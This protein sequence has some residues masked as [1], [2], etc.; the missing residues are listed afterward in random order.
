MSSVR[1]L[2]VGDL[3]VDKYIDCDPVGLSSEDPT[4][5][6]T[7][8]LSQSFVGGAGVVASHAA[9]LGAETYLLSV[10]G[11]DDYAEYA[12]DTLSKNNVQVIIVADGSR[13][14]TVK[15]RYR[16]K[17]KT[18]L[19][20]NEYRDH[21]VDVEIQ[22]NILA[23]A[24]DLFS[25][26]DLLI[27]SDFSYG[28]LSENL[29]SQMMTTARMHNIVIA[30]DSQSSSQIGDI[31]KFRGADI[32]TPTE[33]EARLAT[34]NKNGGLVTVAEELETL[35]DAKTIVLTLGEEGLFA[36]TPRGGKQFD[37]DRIPAL[38]RLP[39]DVA[40]AGDAFLVTTSMAITTGES[41]WPAAYLGSI[42]AGCQVGRLGNVPL[43][44]RE[45]IEG[46]QD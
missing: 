12:T 10:C 32:L 33:R 39:K 21:E 8:I 6:V 9:S 5:V 13:P 35:T 16:A 44:T 14:T 20:I 31:T 17:S 34:R 28:V 18:L 11:K 43:Q 3:I 7:P 42:A 15:T 36:R 26:I 4:V 2:I 30:A 41:L 24:I 29:I 25:E 23:K 40:G 1:T 19:R 22:E 45:L 46:I 27:F 38:N 37:D